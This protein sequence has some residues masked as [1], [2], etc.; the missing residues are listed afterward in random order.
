MTH[1]NLGEE[2]QSRRQGNEAFRLQGVD[3]LPLMA[4]EEVCPILKQYFDFLENALLAHSDQVDINLLQEMLLEISL[5]LRSGKSQLR[6]DGY[7]RLLNRITNIYA[8]GLR[9]EDDR[10]FAGTAAN[11][12]DIL[13]TIS[14]NFQNYDYTHSISLLLHYMDKLFNTRKESWLEVY[15]HLLHIPD[16]IHIMQQLRIYHIDD[17]N[18]WIDEGVDNL[19]TLRDEQLDAIDIQEEALHDL[20]LQIRTR[21][22]QLRKEPINTGVTNISRAGQLRELERLK[23]QYQQLVQDREGKR[24]LVALLDTNIQEFSDRLAE[25]RRSTLMKLV[26]INPHKP[27]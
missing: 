7:L 15:E 5:L 17:I 12:A 11:F 1:Q 18:T 3:H 9:V 22:S 8:R 14:Q 4:Q 2:T 10:A 13:E 6:D 21:Q 26:W 20:Q 24:G 27:S 16:T 19:F 25:M 23:K